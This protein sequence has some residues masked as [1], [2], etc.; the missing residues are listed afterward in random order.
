MA[1]EITGKLIEKFDTQT[2]SE[3]FKKRE[4]VI[5]FQDNPNMSFTEM[6][7]FQLTQDR[8][9]LMDNY[10]VGQEIKVA[11]N[12]RG[13]RWEKDG[14]VNYFTNLEAWKI[15]QASQAAAPQSASSLPEPN[16]S[17]EDAGNDLPF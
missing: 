12:L 11:F 8:C 6:I 4:F 16:N 3:K 9:A 15:E 5:E 2:V 14:N 7:K 13:R 17:I 10:A 1:F